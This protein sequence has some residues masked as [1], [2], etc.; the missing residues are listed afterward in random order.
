[1]ATKIKAIDRKSSKGFATS[2]ALL[3]LGWF[4]CRKQSWPNPIHTPQGL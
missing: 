1:M 4:E 3:R 2:E